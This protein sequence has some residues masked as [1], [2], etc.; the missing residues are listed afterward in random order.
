[1][2]SA[3]VMRLT[4]I[5]R[6]LNPWK[7]KRDQERGRVAALRQRDGDD[8]RRCRRP[9]RFDLTRGHDLGPTI[10]VL[11]NSE[12][13]GAIDRLCLTHGRCNPSMIDHTGEVLERVRRRGEAE[14]LARPRRLRA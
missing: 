7:H 6:Y 9:L 8:C 2:L 1:M 11:P 3:A 5:A 10:A 12:G 13:S 4:I 14:L